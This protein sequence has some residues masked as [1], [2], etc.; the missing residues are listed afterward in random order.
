MWVCKPSTCFFKPQISRSCQQCSQGKDEKGYFLYVGWSK[1]KSHAVFLLVSLSTYNASDALW[2]ALCVHIFCWVLNSGK[3][4]CRLFTITATLLK[5]RFW[6]HT[7]YLLLLHLELCVNQVE[8]PKFNICGGNGSYSLNLSTDNWIKSDRKTSEG[9]RQESL[10]VNITSLHFNVNK[11]FHTSLY[12]L[13]WS[14]HGRGN[15]DW[16]QFCSDLYT[17]PR[18]GKKNWWKWTSC[19]TSLC[20]ISIYNHCTYV[21]IF[22]WLLVQPLT[23]CMC[24]PTVSYILQ[25][26][27]WL[28]YFLYVSV[29]LGLRGK[30]KVIIQC[31]TNINCN[32]SII[33]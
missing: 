30:I 13:P 5:T 2:T 8:G 22:K 32:Q 15:H 21:Y 31:L 6:T 11:T 18:P 23:C 27:T 25:L 1:K 12:F 14:F 17:F 4:A 20:R 3:L 33:I 9:K 29:F 24:F 10:K 16:F 26:V 28:L 19:Q 7:M